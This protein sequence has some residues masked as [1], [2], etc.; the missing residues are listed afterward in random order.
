[1]DKLLNSIDDVKLKLTDMEYKNI[2]DQMAVLHKVPENAF[3]EL[4]YIVVEINSVSKDDLGDFKYM[5]YEYQPRIHK[6]II[7][8]KLDDRRFNEY[9]NNIEIQG[10]AKICKSML[11]KMSPNNFIFKDGYRSAT[12]GNIDL[13]T[14]EDGTHLQRTIGEIRGYEVAGKVPK[15][16]ASEFL[17]EEDRPY[18]EDDTFDEIFTKHV[19]SDEWLVVTSIKKL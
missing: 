14:I 2:C 11:E 10:S 7:K 8:M 13:Q 9:K 5:Q 17:E 1:M 19:H 16:Y 3:Y 15:K 6:K 12:S 18:S 4:A